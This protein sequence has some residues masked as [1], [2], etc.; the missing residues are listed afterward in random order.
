MEMPGVE[1]NQGTAPPGGEPPDPREEIF[2]QLNTA[3][4][5]ARYCSHEHPECLKAVSRIAELVNNCFGD[6]AEIIFT[7]EDGAISMGSRQLVPTEAYLANLAVGLRATEVSSIRLARGLSTDG[8]IRL[9]RLLAA[10]PE[11]AGDFLDGPVGQGIRVERAAPA[12]Q[13][14]AAPPHREPVPEAMWQAEV[15]RLLGG[16]ATTGQ[17]REHDDEH[18]VVLAHIEPRSLA[19]FIDALDL[20]GEVAHIAGHFLVP[21]L[22][23]ACDGPVEEA[24]L[25]PEETASHFLRLLQSLSPGFQVRFIAA[26]MET[27]HSFTRFARRVLEA[28]PLHLAHQAFASIR[29]EEHTVHPELVERF[30]ALCRLTGH[31]AP[32]EIGPAAPSAQPDVSHDGGD[33]TVI[34]S[35]LIEMTG[36]AGGVFDPSPAADGLSPFAAWFS[37][38]GKRRSLVRI[39]LD[40]LQRSTSAREAEL[41]RNSLPPLFGEALQ[42]KD[43]AGLGRDL[44]DL[45]LL[46]EAGR[47]AKPFLD[48]ALAQVRSSF[49]TTNTMALIV[50]A[51]TRESGEQHEALRQ[52]LPLLGPGVADGL[53]RAL[54]ESKNRAQRRS[55]LGAIT[56]F[57]PEAAP[58]AL[59]R[60]TDHRWYVVRNMITIVRETGGREA[61]DQLLTLAGHNQ[62]QIRRELISALLALGHPKGLTLARKGVVS[63]DLKMRSACIGLLGSQRVDGSQD[64]LLQVLADR[65]NGGLP[66]EQ[67]QKTS[68]IWALGQIGN[69]DV[70][71]ELH[72]Y[73]KASRLF[74]K[75][76]SHELKMAILRSLPHYGNAAPVEPLARWGSAH[77]DDEEAALCRRLLETAGRVP[78]DGEAQ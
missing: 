11:Q 16:T 50:D 40:L 36:T 33:G 57:G 37:P 46:V 15:Q 47:S 14:A 60:I 5:V 48:Q 8:L 51:I 43:W 35:P 55:L 34:H 24:G 41:Q 19:A 44:K 7:A 31:D 32:P 1:Q 30:A 62:L 58:L 68:A 61:A 4:K 28:V 13:S 59:R 74:H 75:Q 49:C 77:G 17:D 26:A 56:V 53:I 18:Q 6:T 78:A 25:V 64:T 45:V 10:G 52:W 23:Q 54:I 9:V 2:I 12:K 67:S 63:T 70:L 21:Y 76:E 71:P 22:Y 3:R 72:K 27:S 20:T 39:T 73:L 38:T 42:E 65:V 66:F 29:L 69:G